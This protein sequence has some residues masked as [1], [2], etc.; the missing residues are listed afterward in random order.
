MQTVLKY[1]FYIIAILVIVVIGYFVLSHTIFK[2]SIAE[3]KNCSYPI[4]YN[5]GTISDKFLAEGFTRD[6]LLAIVR[7]E[8][9]QWETALGKKLFEYS[10]GNSQNLINF[11]ADNP[12]YPNEVSGTDIHSFP[13]SSKNFFET[14]I[15]EKLFL[16]ADVIKNQDI[17]TIF[18]EQ[19]IASRSASTS[20]KAVE[21]S[22]KDT[23]WAEAK[24][25]LIQNSTPNPT[26]AQIQEVATVLAQD[27]GIKVVSKATGETLWPQTAGGTIKD[28]SLQKGFAL[29]LGGQDVLE[30]NYDYSSMSRETFINDYIRNIIL[31]EFSHILGF[32][33]SVNDSNAFLGKGYIPL[34]DTPAK[35]TATD[36]MA[37][38]DWC[39]AKK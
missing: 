7:D 25:Q 9:N 28:T 34:P 1:K 39:V 24:R 22:L 10:P 19:Y 14:S 13:D 37:L 33:G 21:T 8:Q 20:E 17:L 6:S 32:D 26:N 3:Y 12:D 2:T 35:F 27:S 18:K 4:I 29:L 36:T 5:I 11:T 16:V 15:Y 31:Y 38:K 30:M 23:I